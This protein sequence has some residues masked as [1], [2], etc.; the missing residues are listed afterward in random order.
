MNYISE[1]INRARYIVKDEGYNS[2]IKR[3]ISYLSLHLF[4]NEEYYVR[5]HYC[6]DLDESDYL[7][8]ISGYT[9]EIVSTNDEAD[10]L[11]QKLGADFREQVLN[12]RRRLDAGAV[13]FCIFIGKDLANIHWQGFSS[14]AKSSINPQP[15]FVDFKNHEGCTGGAETPMKFRK[16]GL[17]AYSC[18]HRNNY[19]KVR[20]IKMLIG[21]DA[22]DN[23][24]IYKVQSKFPSRLRARARYIKIL[25]WKSW[26]EKPLPDDFVPPGFE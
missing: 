11:A 9:I 5:E 8:R 1:R 26:K 18:Y 13:A 20:G 19:M 10:R 2:F 6:G 25:W 15:Y 4:F 14:K 23:I 3:A 12:A 24:A 16:M 7:P 22:T 17:M 21:I